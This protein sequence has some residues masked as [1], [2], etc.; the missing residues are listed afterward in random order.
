MVD[1][2]AWLPKDAKTWEALMRM[3]KLT[4]EKADYERG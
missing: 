4:C 2:F 1:Y 3:L